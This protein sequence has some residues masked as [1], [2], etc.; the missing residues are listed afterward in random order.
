MD[1]VEAAPA[2]D[3]EAPTVGRW[4]V[5]ADASGAGEALAA[6]LEARGHEVRRLSGGDLEPL[7]AEGVREHLAEAV[8]DGSLTGVAHLLAL[9]ATP[10][11]ETDTTTLAA[12]QRRSTGSALLLLQALAAL[13]DSP[14]PRLWIVTR[15][16]Q[17]VGSGPV[18]AVQAPLWGLGRTSAVEHPECWGGLVDLDP[19]APVAA[20]AEALAEILTTPGAENQIALREGHRRVPR[21]S[22]RPETPVEPLAIRGDGSYLV[23]GGHTGLG[24]EVCRRLAE[25]GAGHLLILGRTPLPPGDEWDDL[26]PDSRPGRIAADLAALEGLGAPVTYRSVDVAD[27]ARVTAFLTEMEELGVPPI[28][29]VVHAASVWR[30]G[31]GG[32]LIR[33][34]AQL[35]LEALA[36]VLGPKVLGGFVLHK[37]LAD[38][39]LELFKMFSSGASLLGSAGQGNYAAANSFLD[40]LAHHRHER[41]L[42][43]L[44]VNWGA[45][46]EVGFGA[47]E[48][49]TQVHEQWERNGLHRISPAELLDALFRLAAE[50]SPQVGAM[51]VDWGRL[52][53]LFPDLV[54]SPWASRL[55]EAGSERAPSAVLRSLREA[56]VGD[57]LGRLTDHLQ[58]QIG[59]IMGMLPPTDKRLFELG[60]DSLM[61]V[62]LRNRLEASLE[63]EIRVTTVF[64]FPTIDSLARHLAEEVLG[65]VPPASPAAAPTTAPEA[66]DSVAQVEE[67]SDDEVARRLAERLAARG[68]SS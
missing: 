14:L 39:P 58:E 56:P 38:A 15:G 21:L 47:T 41:G 44:S 51:K 40:A 50:G 53:R 33:S 9:D 57:R 52:G 8:K 27:E 22:R 10:L 62:A 6:S 49:G 42:P 13:P 20:G 36:Q 67:L 48:E 66:R 11:E 54:R 1:W 17:A 68:A 63:A 18:A 2:A 3:T 16:A 19:Q 28:R 65:L 45:V 4:L 12:D 24:L 34:L 23:T 7:S 29:G 43:A 37:H 35:D 60:M 31:A 5:L 55:V 59:D 26:D 61:A 30:D 32:S 46:S 64:N 25:S